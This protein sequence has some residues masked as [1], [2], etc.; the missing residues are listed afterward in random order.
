VDGFRVDRFPGVLIRDAQP[1]DEDA[2]AEV[3]VRAWK[4]AYRGL[5]PAE[6]LDELRPDDRLSG[7]RFGALD[8]E[9][10]QTLLAF[11]RTALLGFSTF[12]ASRDTDAAEAG[13]LFALYVDPDR[14]RVGAGRALLLASR[15]RLHAL[16]HGEAVLWVLRGNQPAERFYE[17]DGWRRDGCSR[18]EDPWGVRSQVFRFRRPLP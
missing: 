18:W 17:A 14:W 5:L 12:G 3:H 13:E 1:G 7:Y 9:A 4:R 6:Y 2:V 8:A 11:D 15:E 10:P 16:G